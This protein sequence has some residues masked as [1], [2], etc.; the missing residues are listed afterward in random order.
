MI[1][2]KT[3]SSY[4][5]KT[6]MSTFAMLAML[7]S[8]QATNYTAVASGNF[9]SNT[10]WSGG[11]APTVILAGDNIS[12]PNGYTVTLDNNV[13]FNVAATLNVDGTLESGTNSTALIM[14]AGNITGAGNIDVDSMSLALVSGVTFTGDIVTDHM[15]SWVTTFNSAA[16]VT[17]NASLWVMAGLLNIMDGSFTMGN[18]ST[19]VIDGGSISVG[20]TGNIGLTGN[21]N[22]VYEGNSSNTGIELTGSGLEDVTIDLSSGAV[23]LTSDVMLD[24]TLDLENGNLIL[25]GNDLTI[26]TNGNIDAN[27][28]GTIN[29]DGNSSITINTM[30]SLNGDLMFGTGNNTVNNLTIN[31]GSSSS[32]VDLGSDVIINGTLTL[33]QGTLTLNSNDLTFAV[34]GNF[35]ASGSGTIVSTSNS[36]IT[37]TSN[38]NFSGGIRFSNT[39]NTV[40]DLT[41]NLGNNSS[42]ASLGS[43]L[44]VDGTLTLTSGMLH[45][46][47]NDLM[48]NTG[49]T[50][51]GG[52][53]NS[54]VITG[55][56]GHL[57][58]N[59]AANGSSMFHVGT[60]DDYTPAMISANT[61]SVA[62][63]ISVMVN[64]SV[65]SQGT[66]G[67]DL[68]ADRSIVNN[69]WF[70]TS[71]ATTGLDLDL[72]LM[73]NAGLEVNN[74]NRNS[75]YIS[76]YTN[77]NWDVA[78]T[79]TAT[80][81]G[82]LFV[83]NRDN[84]T[85]LSPFVVAD[86]NAALKVNNVAAAN[87]EATIYP[88]PATDVVNF[89]TTG[90]VKNVTVFDLS[91]RQ[92]IS[93]PVNGN[94]FSVSELAPGYYNLKLV[95]DDFTATQH[96]VKQ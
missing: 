52:S 87:T 50:V 88:N 22:V 79:T 64:D 84:I 67:Y 6:F 83:M 10:T 61:G 21:Y 34:N 30:G 78:A 44:H 60:E 51:S 86:N 57:T 37:I 4:L 32:N 47:N 8:A 58:I 1:M 73:W 48:L 17:V 31:L 20:G 85:S 75:S 9:S 54:Y 43:D 82:N 19:I 45:T 81:Q 69:T 94:S 16:D 25:N 23:T 66:T 46:W 55:N 38:G 12:I 5:R 42:Y 59:L 63:D 80:A 77:G 11:M 3:Y 90:K 96:F 72:Q 93:A 71:S 65:W 28:N 70:I 53:E 27:G 24:G 29:S 56:G 89:T 95:G 14:T 40:G 26:G 7:T 74:F 68:S 92:V 35:A 76:H 39:G 33:S 91:G 18:N 2:K 62:S 41:I 15:S 49:A 36:D 13:N